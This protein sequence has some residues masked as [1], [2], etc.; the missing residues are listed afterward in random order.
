M[1][2]RQA[3]VLPQNAYLVADGG[4]PSVYPLIT[5]FRRPRGRHLGPVQKRINREIGRARIGVEHGIANIHAFRSVPGRSGRFR[6]RRE[7][8]PLVTNVV[9]VVALANRRRRLIQSIREQLLNE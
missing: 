9:H 2:F 7:L 8:V 6:H 4:Y 3:L 1:G 5:P